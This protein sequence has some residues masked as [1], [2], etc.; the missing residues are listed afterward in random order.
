[1]TD[2]QLIEFFATKANVRLSS[3]ITFGKSGSGYVR[4]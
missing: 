2:E 1:M 3:G 4:D